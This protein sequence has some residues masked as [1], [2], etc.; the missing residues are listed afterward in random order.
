MVSR[1]AVATHWICASVTENCRAING[2]DTFTMPTS[3]VDIKVPI[4]TTCNI[5]HL[6]RRP[7][8]D[9]FLSK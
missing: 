4:F 9:S 1:Y 8:I 5:P 2:S 6:F 3:R 7:D